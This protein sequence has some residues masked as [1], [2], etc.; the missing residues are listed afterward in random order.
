MIAAHW[1]VMQFGHLAHAS[2]TSAAEMSHQGGAWHAKQQAV[3]RFLAYM[4]WLACQVLCL[5]LKSP[6][7]PIKAEKW[8]TR[9]V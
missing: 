5:T 9:H 2:L 3:A 6:T 4:C 7:G 8:H 1:I